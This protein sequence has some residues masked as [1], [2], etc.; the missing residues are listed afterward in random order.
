MTANRSLLVIAAGILGLT[1]LAVLIVVLAGSG[2]RQTFEPGSP[3]AAMQ[4]YLDAWEDEDY[5]R[6][7]GHLS[8]GARDDVSLAE[9][10]GAATNYYGGGD[11]PRRAV[12]I[13]RVSGDG[14]RVRVELTV[15]EYHGG[16]GLGGGGAHRSPREVT[17]V[18]E[19]GAWRIDEPLIWLDPGPFA[20]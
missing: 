4:D 13:D 5:E 6:A 10:R 7:Y 1:A 12:Y 19:D 15:E 17:M 20:F 11:G 9:Y 8:A 16:G 2:G 18:H 3:Q 14:D